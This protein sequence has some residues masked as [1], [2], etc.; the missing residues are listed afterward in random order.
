MSLVVLIHNL[1]SPKLCCVW[2]TDSGNIIYVLWC[3]KWYY[4]THIFCYICILTLF[5]ISSHLTCC[6]TGLWGH[7]GTHNHIWYCHN[8]KIGICGMLHITRCTQLNILPP[9]WISTMNT[10]IPM[11]TPLPL[12]MVLSLHIRQALA[13]RLH[14]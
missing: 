5:I 3:I 4:F 12:H 10:T 8:T 6:F 13:L 2:Y 11:M 7:H 1:H 9:P 14:I